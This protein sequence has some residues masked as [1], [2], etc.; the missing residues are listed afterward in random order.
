MRRFFVALLLTVCAFNSNAARNYQAA[1]LPAGY[2]LH[3]SAAQ[4]VASGCVSEITKDN[5]PYSSIKVGGSDDWTAISAGL[6][7]SSIGTTIIYVCQAYSGATLSGT[8]S[9]SVTV[10]QTCPLA[11][12]PATS[13]DYTYI[14][15]YDPTGVQPATTTTPV[16]NPQC[17]NKCVIQRPAGG[18]GLTCELYAAAGVTPAVGVG[19]WSLCAPHNG[20]VYTSASCNYTGADYTGVTDTSTD[21]PNNATPID[22][23]AGQGTTLAVDTSTTCLDANANGY[24]DDTGVACSVLAAAQI[25]ALTELKKQQMDNVGTGATMS[26]DVNTLAAQS[27]GIFAWPQVL[28][29]FLNPPSTCEFQFVLNALPMLAALNVTAGW[30]SIKTAVEP[31]LAFGMW[32]ITIF[33][34]A[35]FFQ[36]VS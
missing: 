9:S 21:F 20:F 25:D 7:A 24:D 29:N 35:G 13:I 2:M 11:E 15:T 31:F 12:T 34:S 30:C 33:V 28:L 26:G 18:A 1:N 17:S 8:A 19:V 36:R 16:P 23:F 4:A 5:L 14:A 10:V 32:V 6:A 22:D 3:V 27:G